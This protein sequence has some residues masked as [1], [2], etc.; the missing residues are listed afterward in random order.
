MNQ[1]KKLTFLTI[2]LTILFFAA[3]QIQASCSIVIQH[4]PCAEFW[5]ADAVFIATASDV[6]TKPQRF[7]GVPPITARLTIEEVFKGDKEKEIVI[8]SNDCGYQ[9]KQ[10][11][12]YLIYA[13]RHGNKLNVIIGTTRT[14]PLAEA[15]EDLEYLRSLQ[16]SEPQAQIV[17]KIGQQ[18]ADIKSVR[19]DSFSSD[20]FFF[21]SPMSNVKVFARNAGQ[22]Y[23]T[24]SDTKGEYKFFDLP[25]GEYQVW[26]DY[27]SYFESRVQ[28]IKTNTQSCGIGDFVTRRKGAIFGHV[29]GADGA[30]IP[31]LLVSLVF[32]DATPQEI[33][34]D[35]KNKSVWNLASTD[36]K[37]EYGFT[38]LPAGRYFVIVN[39]TEYERKGGDG[40]AQEI[41]R[42]FY[43]GVGTI[44]KATVIS[45]EEGEQIKGKDI[46]LQKS[47]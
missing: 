22:T 36:A 27:P 1:M 33:F 25:P 3:T 17:G 44:E 23:E 29:R 10:G 11:E 13:H 45:I 37:G 18:T 2:A 9:F 47:K 19:E 4:P 14:K 34:E 28:T 30:P 32:A 20:W 42:L 5:R 31:D 41:P 43:P 16:R 8:E 46:R 15:A 39:R 40:R 24:F 38:M 26:A 7:Q 6:E 12:K 35:R 21:G